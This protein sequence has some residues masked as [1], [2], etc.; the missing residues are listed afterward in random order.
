[1]MSRMDARYETRYS[2]LLRGNDSNHRRAARFDHSPNGYIG[3]SSQEANGD[4]SDRVLLTP[5]Q[6]KRLIVFIQSRGRS[7][8]I[9]RATKATKAKRAAP[10]RRSAAHKKSL[11]S[12]QLDALRSELRK[13]RS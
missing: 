8:K 7:T 3:I 12:E 2:E 10:T 13:D 6:A 11:N 4:W 1:M 5:A 9:G